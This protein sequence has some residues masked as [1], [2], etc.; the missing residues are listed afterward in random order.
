[1]R[2]LKSTTEGDN[3]ISACRG[4]YVEPCW[5]LIAILEETEIS[6]RRHVTTTELPVRN[7]STDCDIICT[8]TLNSP[9]VKS[10][11]ENIVLDSAIDQSCS[12]QKLCLENFIRLCMRV[13]SFTYAR[14]FMRK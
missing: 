7:I 8:S 12:A 4:G 13:H 10:L 3:S 6:F 5:D 9:T 11:W 2:S 1:M 14:D